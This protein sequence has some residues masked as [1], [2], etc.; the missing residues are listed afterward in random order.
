MLRIMSR[1]GRESGWQRPG[2]SAQSGGIKMIDLIRLR[3]GP[4]TKYHVQGAAA[5]DGQMRQLGIARHAAA[6]DARK[7]GGGILYAAVCVYT[8]RD[9]TRIV[10]P[11]AAGRGAAAPEILAPDDHRFSPGD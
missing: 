4:V 6:E 8:H 5:I 1:A 3:V 11:H 2:V 7:I 9:R 10:Q